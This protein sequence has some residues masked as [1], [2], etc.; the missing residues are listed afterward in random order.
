MQFDQH[1]DRRPM[2]P[3]SILAQAYAETGFSTSVDQIQETD[4]KNE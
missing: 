1:A 3:M 2:H 4:S